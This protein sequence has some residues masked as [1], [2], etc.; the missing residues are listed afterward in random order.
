VGD[1]A[2]S[3]ARALAV[4]VAV[5]AL[6]QAVKAIVNGTLALG[7]SVAVFPGLDIVNVRNRGVAFGM[8]ADGGALLVVLTAVALIALLAFF[9]THSGRP[10]VWLPVG[11]LLG[12]AAGN[13]IDRARQ[14]SVTDYIDPVLW[15][16]FNVADIAITL[17]VLSLLYV[18][19]GAPARRERE[20]RLRGAGPRTPVA[21]PRDDA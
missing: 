6:D 8:F 18:L 14:G 1:R 20:Q 12:G 10:L 16:A 4:M 11:L 17:G 15:P 5:V 9:L 13:L 21:G 3:T 19:E 2:R 7:E